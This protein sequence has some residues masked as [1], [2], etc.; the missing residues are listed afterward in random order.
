MTNKLPISVFIIAKDEADRIPL[1]INSVRDWVDEII[2]IDSG[3]NDETVEVSKQLGAK[4]LFNEWEG[5]G[6]QKIF[7]EGQCKNDWV[8]NLDADEEVTDELKTEITSLFTQGTPKHLAYKIPILPFYPF[9]EKPIKQTVHNAPVRLYNKKFAT[10]NNHP[11]HD[12]VIV[13]KDRTA[14]LKGFALHR[15]FRSLSHQMQKIDFYSNGQADNLLERGR[16]PGRLE[17]LLVPPLAFIKFY[18]FRKGFLL[19]I[20]GI[21]LG[22]MY[23]FHRFLRIAKVREMTVMKNKQ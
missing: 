12:Y 14:Q 22:H 13:D 6:P 18:I 16:I 10:Y 15:T 11:I 21:I 9:Q 19:G 2:V 7:G 20:D 5:Y 8:F 17:L 3:S 23:A 4:V 1:T